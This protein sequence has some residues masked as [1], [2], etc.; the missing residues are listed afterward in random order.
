MCTQQL[1]VLHWM[2][3]LLI[4]KFT[5]HR[6]TMSLFFKNGLL[7]EAMY[8]LV[9]VGSSF[10]LWNTKNTDR[11]GVNTKT[12]TPHTEKDNFRKG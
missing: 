10:L 3:N 1:A 9:K 7:V 6:P 8:L 5:L 12:C 2:N 11:N 4:Q